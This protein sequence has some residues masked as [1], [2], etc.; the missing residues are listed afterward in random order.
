MI[1]AIVLAAG[2]SSRM[3]E[4]KPLVP[5]DGQPSL[6]HVL[7][8]LKQAGVETPI[9]VLGAAAEEIRAAVDLSDCRVRVNP[10]PEEGL[11]SSLRLGLEAVE[12]DAA[13][14]LIAMS[15]MPALRPETIRSVI[16][17]A[18]NGAQIAAPVFE[19]RRGFPVFLARALFSELAAT[20]AGD[21][22]ARAFLKRHP[23]LLMTVE[24]DDPGSVQ[25]F[26]RAEDLARFERS[27]PC[28]TSA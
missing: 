26:D 24:V 19:G 17:L 25:D 15:D 9:V 20:L 1:E 16:A 7:S 18:D 4:P 5:I 14:A 6:S 22:G 21:V 13:G 23:Q 8:A 3:G 27:S 12:A 2:L 10:A 11:S 28:A